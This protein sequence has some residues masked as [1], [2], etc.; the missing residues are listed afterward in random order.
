MEIK[1]PLQVR[2]NE[3]DSKHAAIKHTKKAKQDNNTLS[4]C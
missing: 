3:T 2:N 4:R 1:N